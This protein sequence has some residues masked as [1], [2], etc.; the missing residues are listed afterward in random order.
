MTKSY[1]FYPLA[2]SVDVDNKYAPFTY[3]QEFLDETDEVD[4]SAADAFVEPAESAVQES[5]TESVVQES[6]TES[7]ESEAAE[8]AAAAELAAASA[9]IAATQSESDEQISEIIALANQNQ[10]T[11]LASAQ[12]EIANSETAMEASSEAVVETS[13]SSEAVVETSSSEEEESEGSGISNTTLLLI[14]AL[15]FILYK[16]RKK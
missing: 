4:A 2:N 12:N 8:S 15:C 5:T 6:T 10:E 11:A 16:L 14:L 13:S 7:A 3:T 9:M 1:N